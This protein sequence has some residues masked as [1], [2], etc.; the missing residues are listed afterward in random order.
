MS[1]DVSTQTCF[2]SCT[3]LV[4]GCVGDALYAESA[5]RL[6]GDVAKYCNDVK[7]HY[8]STHKIISELKINLLNR[9]RHIS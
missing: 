2:E 1:S 4:N 7:L 3:P 5:T 8:S 6:A 9:I